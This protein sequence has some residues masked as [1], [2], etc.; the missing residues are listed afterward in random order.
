MYIFS[1]SLL[2]S[3][4]RSRNMWFYSQSYW[5]IWHY[6]LDF[7]RIKIWHFSERTYFQH[8]S[9]IQRITKMVRRVIF[10]T[11]GIKKLPIVLFVDFKLIQ[12]VT[13]SFTKSTWVNLVRMDLIHLSVLFS[14][15]IINPINEKLLFIYKFWSIFCTILRMAEVLFISVILIGTFFIQCNF[16]CTLK[17]F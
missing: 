7:Y 3:S 6:I 11:P 12:S 1:K 8:K 17:H 2:A 14:Q 13:L 10:N 5:H 16:W 15:I 9:H 4:M